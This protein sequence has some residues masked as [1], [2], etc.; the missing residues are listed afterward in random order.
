MQFFHSLCCNS[1]DRIL[2]LHHERCDDFNL[3]HGHVKNDAQIPQITT[4]IFNTLCDR[5]ISVKER[6][7]RKVEN[8]KN[9]TAPFKNRK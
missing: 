5:L 6:S 4:S 1:S 2:L 3:D 9:A 7:E 8:H